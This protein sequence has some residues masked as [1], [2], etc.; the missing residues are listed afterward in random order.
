MA[1]SSSAVGVAT[2]T[3][4]S[5]TAKSAVVEPSDAVVPNKNL[6][7][8][9]SQIITALL[10]S[11]PLLI[12]I[13]E[14]WPTEPELLITIRLSSTAKFWES[15]VVVVPCTVR[16]PVIR[17]LPLTSSAKLPGDV[18]FTPNL[19]LATSMYNKSVSNA[20]S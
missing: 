5:V 18:V 8:D 10:P 16:S 6:S 19:P 13:P 12:I 9:S 3:F 4:D 20:R 14:L 11:D 17:V 1:A 15:T 7:V 2:C